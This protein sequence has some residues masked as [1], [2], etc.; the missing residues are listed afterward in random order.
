M[1]CADRLAITTSL[2]G[3]GTRALDSTSSTLRAFKAT[4]ERRRAAVVAQAAL[5]EWISVGSTAPATDEHDSAAP[6]N[7]RISLQGLT[8][9]PLTARGWPLLSAHCD[10]PRGARQP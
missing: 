3:E 2:L 5:A 1:T 8:E 9:T 7:A 6:P 10:T 4:R